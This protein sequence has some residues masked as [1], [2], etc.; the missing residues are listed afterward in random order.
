MTSVW[1]KFNLDDVPC[2][3]LPRPENIA[4]AANHRRQRLRPKDPQDLE[5]ELATDHIPSEF[6][7]ADLRFWSRRHLVF[8]TDQQLEFLHTRSFSHDVTELIAAMLVHIRVTC[9]SK[10]YMQTESKVIILLSSQSKI[11]ASEEQKKILR[12]ILTMLFKFPCL[13]TLKSWMGKSESATLRKS[14][15]L[16]SIL[17]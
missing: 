2:P 5:F 10:K 17:P 7:H 8:A 3:S 15:R 11:M 16:E 1:G 6:L 4:R 9:F 14:R 12:L 13:I